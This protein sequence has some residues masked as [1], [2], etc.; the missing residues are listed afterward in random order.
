MADL[1]PV[2]QPDE[3]PEVLGHEHWVPLARRLSW[4]HG[5]QGRL[6]Q[7]LEDSDN[8]VA[9]VDKRRGVDVTRLWP[10]LLWTHGRRIIGLVGLGL[11]RHRLPGRPLQTRLLE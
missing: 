11:D 2:D 7:H 8:A 1:A 4:W 6:L 3:L 5:D 10:A 9:S